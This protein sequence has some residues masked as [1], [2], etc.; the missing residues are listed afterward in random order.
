M[1]LLPSFNIYL[2]FASLV[3][4]VEIFLVLTSVI[5][6]KITLDS[7]LSTYSSNA[8]CFS[9]ACSITCLGM[10]SIFLR[11]Y[12]L[13]SLPDLYVVGPAPLSC[14]PLS[15][16]CSCYGNK[17]IEEKAILWFFGQKESFVFHLI[18]VFINQL[19]AFA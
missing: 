13:V 1:H 9:S 19:S 16:S 11:L 17:V 7:L 3:M 18:F 5:V 2:Y 10:T 4:T 12:S 15:L 14:T 6:I 8:V